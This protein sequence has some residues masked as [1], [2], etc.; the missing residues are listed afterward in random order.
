MAKKLWEHLDLGVIISPCSVPCHVRAT[1]LTWRISRSQ[2]HNCLQSQYELEWLMKA[3]KWKWY[4]IKYCMRCGC[5]TVGALTL[6][7]RPHSNLML[8]MS[9]PWRRCSTESLCAHLLFFH[10]KWKVGSWREGSS[11]GQLM[12]AGGCVCF[13]CG[14]TMTVCI[15][16]WLRLLPRVRLMAWWW[17]ASY[18]HIVCN[19]HQSSFIISDGQQCG[20]LHFHWV[21]WLSYCIV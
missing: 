10:W 15:H 9:T 6:F 18:S 13:V 4:V 14:I 16:M 17:L 3:A 7:S 5:A 11:T 1:Y 20:H 2:G 19:L 12:R 8:Y 21:D